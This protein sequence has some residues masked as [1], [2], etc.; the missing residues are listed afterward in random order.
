MRAWWILLGAMA[1]IDGVVENPCDE[2]ADYLCTCGAED[3]EQVRDQLDSSDPGVQDSCRIELACF[4]E[5]DDEVGQTCILFDEG[6]EGECL[7]S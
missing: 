4:D 6:R 5:A 7:A 2:Y 3:C 1:C